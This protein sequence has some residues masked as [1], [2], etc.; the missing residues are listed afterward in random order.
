MNIKILGVAGDLNTLDNCIK[1]MIRSTKR[2]VKNAEI[3]KVNEGKKV[4]EIL[5]SETRFLKRTTIPLKK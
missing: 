2:L 1:S 4:L 3:L 5:E